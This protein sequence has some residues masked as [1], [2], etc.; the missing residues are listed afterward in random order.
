MPGCRSSGSRA[1]G[2]S[3]R[4][5]PGRVLAGFDGIL[6]PGGFGERGIEGKID[7]IRFAREHDMPF[8]GICLG[9]QCA[10]IEFA[11]NV[12]RLPETPTAPSSTPDCPTPV[13][14]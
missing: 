8:F 5:R 13:I 11:R 4:K 6:V 2:S 14:A 1:T 10:V 3:S 12:C 9:L 7:A